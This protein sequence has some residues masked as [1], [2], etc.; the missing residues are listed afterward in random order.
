MYE[1]RFFG[2]GVPELTRIDWTL[3]EAETG[4]RLFFDTM[5]GEELLD[6]RQAGCDGRM[7]GMVYWNTELNVGCIAGTLIHK[8]YPEADVKG[9]IEKCA[10]LPLI[11]HR[12]DSAR[13]INAVVSFF[14]N[15]IHMNYT[16]ENSV[17]MALFIGWL[18]AFWK[19]A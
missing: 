11:A 3:E 8:R 10:S 1:L 2:E 9:I 15:E 5:N 6:M 13:G 7:E 19:M 18:D 4:A 17:A 16:P 12:Y 14:F